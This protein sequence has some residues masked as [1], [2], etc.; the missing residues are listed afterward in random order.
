MKHKLNSSAEGKTRNIFP[1]F[2]IKNKAKIEKQKEK[3][4]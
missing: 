3:G 2:S 1:E 4:G